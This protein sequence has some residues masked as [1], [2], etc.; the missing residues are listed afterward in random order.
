[1]S[2]L[3]HVDDHNNITSI[4]L[5]G[6]PDL[7]CFTFLFFSVLLFIYCVTITGNL[8]IIVL[9]V[10][11]NILHSPMYF[12]ISQLSLFD[13]ILSTDILPNL[14][15]II[16]HDGCTM[17]LTGCISQFFFFAHAEFS[18]CFL[19]TLMS[20]D[21][22]LAI[23][24][25]LHYNSLMNPSI[26]IK[27]L[28]IIWLLGLKMTLV[29]TISLFSLHYCGPNI[30]DH[31]FCD[32]EPILEL[33]CSDT[34]FIQ[35]QTLVIGFLCVIVPFIL[36]VLSYFYISVTILKI[37]SITGRQKAFR[38][39]SS[40]LTAVCIF[41]GTLTAVYLFPTKGEL[42]ILSKVLSLFYTVITPFLNPIIYTFRNKDFKKAIEKTI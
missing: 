9:F 37:Q 33:S 38:T 11:S 5:T 19:L 28:I 26:C 3:H 6:F 18:E 30:I 12:F 1:M 36:I 15:H 2:A 29:D 27:S 34:L 42:S 20:Y 10:L 13:I 8:F 35:N 39:C 22:Y 17:S 4:V 23:C 41:Y 40:H 16:L 21:R 31:F 14:L 32:F 7:K 25:P 24:K